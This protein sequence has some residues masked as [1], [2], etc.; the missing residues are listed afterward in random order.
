MHMSFWF[1]TKLND[2]LF[3]GY[4]I[5]TTWGFISTCLGL[6]ALAVIYEVMK[7]FQIRLHEK[8]KE[9]NQVSNPVQNTDSSSLISRASERSGAV[10]NSSKWYLYYTLLY[11]FYFNVM[12][13]FLTTFFFQ[14]HVDKMVYRSFSLVNS[15][16][17][18]V[19]PYASCNDIQW[20]H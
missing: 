8:A 5:T 11:I 10:V 2:F 18:R 19:L 13:S 20:L 4:N 6:S 3:Y 7:V 1:G 12:Q 14:L 15:C 16:Y 17:L 9:H